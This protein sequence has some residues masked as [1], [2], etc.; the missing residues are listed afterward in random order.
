MEEEIGL[1]TELTRLQKFKGGSHNAYEHAVLFKTHA[2]DV[3]YFDPNE[4]ASLH[5]FDLETID[6]MIE[7]DA[8]RF[9]PPFLEQ[10]QWYRSQ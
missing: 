10:Y 1:T 2:D 3:T 9:T 7:E 8:S 6:R 4:I 5:F